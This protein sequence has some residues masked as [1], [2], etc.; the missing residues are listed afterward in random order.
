MMCV[1]PPLGL[2]MMEEGEE[3]FRAYLVAKQA[4]EFPQ[5]LASNTLDTKCLPAYKLWFLLSTH[6]LAAIRHFLWALLT[7]Q[8]TIIYLVHM[9]STCWLI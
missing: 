2:A 7:L 4:V 5:V 6:F 3:G 1:Q 8:L 9:F